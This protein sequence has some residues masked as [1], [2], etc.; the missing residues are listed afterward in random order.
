MKYIAKNLETEPA[1][2]EKWVVAEDQ[3]G[4]FQ[5]QISPSTSSTVYLSAI[6]GKQKRGH[7]TLQT[8]D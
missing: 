6:R 1:E 2:F 5:S 3:L 4:C 8:R 7:G